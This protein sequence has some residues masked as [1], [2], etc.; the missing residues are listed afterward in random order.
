MSGLTFYSNYLNNVAK[1]PN[2]QW[3]EEQ[4]AFIDEMFDNSTVMRTDDFE[5]GYPFDFNFVN[6]PQCWANVIHF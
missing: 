4:Q 1:S 2:Q 3:R 6:N 5:E